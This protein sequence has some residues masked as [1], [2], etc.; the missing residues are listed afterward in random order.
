MIGAVLAKRAGHEAFAAIN[1]RDLEA[2]VGMFAAD[3][4]FEFPGH[5]AMAGRFSGKE[6]IRSWF[7]RWF[8]EMQPH[9][10]LKHVSV[11]RIFAFGATNTVHV[12]WELDEVNQAGERFH[13]T[14]VT[15]LHARGGKAVLVHDYIP[16]Q[17]VLE[18]AWP[19][20]AHA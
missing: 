13:M 17:D 19:V 11:E 16:D 6:A 5:S 9:F 7:E 12:E 20:H 14:G 8:Q 10:T 15:A 1:R 4:V 18:R 3:G 2:I